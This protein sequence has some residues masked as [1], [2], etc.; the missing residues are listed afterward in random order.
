MSNKMNT[1]T[2]SGNTPMDTESSIEKST[3]ASSTTLIQNDLPQHHLAGSSAP[4]ATSLAAPAKAKEK[5]SSLKS[6]LQSAVSDWAELEKKPAQKTPEEEQMD[7][8]RS[9]ISNLKERLA[10][11]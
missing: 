5:W 3:A 9:L 1:T 11:F 8:V 4:A 2:P 6:N 7:K 10:E